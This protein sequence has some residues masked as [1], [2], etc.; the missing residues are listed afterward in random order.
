MPGH[1]GPWELVILAVVLLLVFGPKRLPE[2]GRGVGQMVK[3]LRD[4]IRDMRDDDGDEPPK[5]LR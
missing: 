1:V 5:E 4:T 3:E 2:V